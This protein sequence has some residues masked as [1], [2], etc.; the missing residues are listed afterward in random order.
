MVFTWGILG[1]KLYD[2]RTAPLLLESR[3]SHPWHPGT[4]PPRGGDD[5]GALE[6]LPPLA[7]WGR[8]RHAGEKGG[9]PRRLDLEGSGPDTFQ[10]ETC[11]WQLPPLA[12]WDGSA[13]RGKRSSFFVEEYTTAIRCVLPPLASWTDGSAMRGRRARGHNVGCKERLTEVW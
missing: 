4:G 7:P 6:E 3:C 11:D 10:R 12:P 5:A 9:A 1:N 2:A 8:V 13:T